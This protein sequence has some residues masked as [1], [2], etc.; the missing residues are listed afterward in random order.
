M[1]NGIAYPLSS[2]IFRNCLITG[3]GIDELNGEHSAEENNPFNYYFSYCLIHSVAEE[4]DQIVNVLWSK[5]EHFLKLD[6]HSQL[7]DFRLDASSKAIDIGKVA[8]AQT[9]PLDRNGLSRLQD[10]APDAGC[11][12]RQ[13]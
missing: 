5:E 8:D 10:D 3:S 11:Y 6:I 12:E 7:Y 4:N 13:P 1:Q 2:A 9:Y